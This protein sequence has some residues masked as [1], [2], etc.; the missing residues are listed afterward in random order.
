ME[1]SVWGVGRERRWEKE[2]GS[3]EYLIAG[4]IVIQEARNVSDKHISDLFNGGKPADRQHEDSQA[5]RTR[6]CFSSAC[7][8]P[9]WMESFPADLKL[10]D[11]RGNA[12]KSKPMPIVIPSWWDRN[13]S[14][15]EKCH[16]Y[17]YLL[18]NSMTDLYLTLNQKKDWN[19]KHLFL[20]SVIL[21]FSV[22]V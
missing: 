2:E 17:H 3:W 10:G 21:S 13:H 19:Y 11:L 5:E 22:W 4:C 14:Y 8:W 20:S 9:E 16:E 15:W 7:G 18:L 12:W 6:I 1:V